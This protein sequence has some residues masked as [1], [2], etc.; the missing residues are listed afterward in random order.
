MA[1]IS[2]VPV[3][4]E[5]PSA[6]PLH[7]W[8]PFEGLRREIDRL[9]DDFDGGGWP[10]LA[11]RSLFDTA[12]FAGH[13]WVTAPAVDFA[14]TEKGYEVTAEFPAWTKRTSRLSTPMVS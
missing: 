3:K 4:T 1:E 9:F 7:A 11:R 10:R 5:K 2:K 14:E 8:R 13:A 12:P 6:S